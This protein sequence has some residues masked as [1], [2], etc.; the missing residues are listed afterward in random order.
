MAA[1]I[2]GRL[3]RIAACY[4]QAS[5]RLNAYDKPC[6]TEAPNLIARLRGLHDYAAMVN[7]YQVR[8]YILWEAE[9]R[10]PGSRKV[11][12]AKAALLASNPE[13]YLKQPQEYLGIEVVIRL[14]F[15]EGRQARGLQL[16]SNYGP[17]LSYLRDSQLGPNMLGID[18]DRLAAEYARSIGVNVITAN[19]AELPFAGNGFDLVFSHNF[20]VFNY[21]ERLDRFRPGRHGT[22]PF[23]ARVLSEV[24]RVLRPGG[25]FIS[26]QE[27]LGG[28]QVGQVNLNPHPD[29]QES[30]F[31]RRETPLLKELQVFKK[32]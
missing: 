2:N 8:C 10:Q 15:G 6:I 12:H 31:N 17:Y 7:E 3:A 18:S 13:N 29:F 4:W 24:S 20:L 14:L 23:L 1:P 28:D 16:A 30:W 27:Y 32:A 25:I 5:A 11:E 21:E 26:S 9:V 22:E 19:A